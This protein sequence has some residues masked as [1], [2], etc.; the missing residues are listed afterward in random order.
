MSKQRQIIIIFNQPIDE[1][2]ISRFYLNKI[3]KISKN[4]HII[5]FHK[6]SKVKNKFINSRLLKINIK[7]I[8]R[9]IF[10]N[11][12][13]CYIDLSNR[14]IREI[15][16][17]RFLSILGYKR[18]TLDVGLIPVQNTRFHILKNN[19][20]NNEY[21]K[22][23][24]NII[25]RFI[26]KIFYRFIL[27]KVDLAFTSGTK[28]KFLSKQSGAKKIIEAHNLDYDNFLNIKKKIHK[29]KYAVYI[30]QDLSNNE[31][32]KND[33]VKFDNRKFE[34][35]IDIFLNHVNSTTIKIQVAGSNRRNLKKNLF[36]LNTKYFNTDRMIAECKFVI[37]HNS[38][39]LQYAIL[40]DK[41]IL[42]IS[43]KEIENINQIYKH[44]LD[45]KKI[46]GC[47]L[48]SIDSKKKNKI[49]FK[50]INKKKYSIY[51]NKYIKSKSS[52][53]INFFRIFK[54]NLT[55]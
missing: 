7:S 47:Q 13:G 16:F 33:G 34:K 2:N 25:T 55:F 38:T 36:K 30:D 29:K 40:F 28:G 9:L 37:G 18:I 39:A 14:S 31:D 42:L 10:Y 12:K 52:I 5:N 8:I 45:F 54:N 50:K 41:P 24:S 21:L 22:F 11:E 3:A 1:R 43:T 23:I 17:L 46:T 44:M 20:N 26:Y 32:L 49:F 48:L 53:N 19:L 15:I 6:K 51:I 35:K 27:P 4:F